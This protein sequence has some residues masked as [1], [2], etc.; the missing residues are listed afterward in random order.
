MRF[1]PT[2]F[3]M[4][5]E[6][7]RFAPVGTLSLKVHVCR[8]FP[9]A[10]DPSEPERT[11]SVTIVTTPPRTNVGIELSLIERH[12]QATIRRNGRDET[13]APIPVT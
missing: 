4:A 13:P 6:R 9:D 7:K 8:S 2:T 10:T 1:E 5:S 11:T 3:C 12:S